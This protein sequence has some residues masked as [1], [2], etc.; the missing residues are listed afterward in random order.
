MPNTFSG[1]I[2]DAT[3][4]PNKNEWALLIEDSHS[5]YTTA[6][7]KRTVKATF[8]KAI[9]PNPDTFTMSVLLH[10]HP[11]AA[12]CYELEDELWD[13][14]DVLF[15]RYVAGNSPAPHLTIITSEPYLD[16]EGRQQ[17]DL[18]PPIVGVYSISRGLLV[19]GEERIH[20]IKE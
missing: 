4:D 8:R 20:L 5:M 7:D 3:Y 19:A 1:T 18:Y 14:V 9:N 11:L 12:I 15:N 17:T 13:T 6:F 10:P 2:D 16:A